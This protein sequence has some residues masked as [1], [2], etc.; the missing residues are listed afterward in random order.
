MKKTKYSMK[1]D[2]WNTVGKY[3]VIS[4]KDFESILND[5]KNQIK[6]NHEIYG[7]SSAE[8][9]ESDIEFF[10]CDIVEKREETKFSIITTYSIFDRT[11]LIILKKE[12][13]KEGYHFKANK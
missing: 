1:F 12:E 4:K 6:E 13:C 9:K 10:L 8:V 7:E 5:Y 2:T 3:I 11:A